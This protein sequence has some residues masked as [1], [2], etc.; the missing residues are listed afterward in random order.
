[1]S[2]KAPLA[3]SV[4]LLSIASMSHAQKIPESVYPPLEPEAAGTSDAGNR[5][6]A[7]GGV[8]YNL[9]VNYMTDYVWRGIE[10]FDADR[11]E[12]ALNLQLSNKLQLDLGKLP[13]P[14]VDVFVNIG[15][16]DP[17]S[18]FN[19]V[20]PTVGFDWPVRPFTIS[21]GHISY[22]F[23]SRSSIDTSELF[24][25][26]SFDD[27]Q[28]FR[29][30]QALLKPYVYAAYDYDQWDGLYLEAG[31]Q[32][33]WKLENTGLS[34]TLD[35]HV[36]YINGHRG[37]FASV[38]PARSESGFQHWQVGVIGKY[39][40]NTLLNIPSRFGN[41]SVNGYV[42]YTDGIDTDLES[43]TQIYGG[44]GISLSF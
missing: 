27:S 15:N 21:A 32:P 9:S 26:I 38:D 5:D 35:A 29:S 4:A 43:T 22:I 23:P 36:S 40:L 30:E 11:N 2:L 17:I 34:I 14:Y 12:D 10:R 42:Y 33:T 1:M 20:R 44:A 19:E 41:W 6:G 24:L 18:S 37:L 16:D 3:V 8:K 39:D 7:I 31:I 28:L 25:K 13:H